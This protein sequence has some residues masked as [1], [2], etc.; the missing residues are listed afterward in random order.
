MLKASGRQFVSIESSSL[1]VS[2]SLKG[3]KIYD[4]H[5]QYTND[6]KGDWTKKVGS[7]DVSKAEL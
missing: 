1:V 6:L 2:E 5:H 7:T 4:N 3:T